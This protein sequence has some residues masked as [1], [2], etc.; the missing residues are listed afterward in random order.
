MPEADPQDGGR[1]M[2]DLGPHDTLPHF[3]SLLEPQTE[4][5]QR[6]GV[7]GK[8]TGRRKSVASQFQVGAAS[9]KVSGTVWSGKGYDRRDGRRWGLCAAFSL[10][11][12][13]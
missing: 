4:G 10:L 5:R 2:P 7:G 3:T 11:R 13:V 9:C 8:D 6:G 12:V 1:Q